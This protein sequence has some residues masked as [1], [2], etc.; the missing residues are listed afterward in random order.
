MQVQQFEVESFNT[1]YNTRYINMSNVR[2]AI[3]SFMPFPPM[4]GGEKSGWKVGSDGSTST[5]ESDNTHNSVSSTQKNTC[6]PS[7]DDDLRKQ[8]NDVDVVT[9]GDEGAKIFDFRWVRNFRG[10]LHR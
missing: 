8:L 9:I 7:P 1:N 10:V 2:L 6:Q 5:S 3:H 4:V